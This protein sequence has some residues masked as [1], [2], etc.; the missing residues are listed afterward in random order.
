MV[1]ARVTDSRNSLVLLG[2]ALDFR[3][4][5]SQSG[6]LATRTFIVYFWSMWCPFVTIYMVVI[7]L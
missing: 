1:T 2:G 6:Q 4:I 3:K 7:F 5:T